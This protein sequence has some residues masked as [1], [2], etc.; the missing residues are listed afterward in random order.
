MT[1]PACRPQQA[2]SRRETDVTNPGP[3][4]EESKHE[5]PLTG[6]LTCIRSIPIRLPSRLR[7]SLHTSEAYL[8]ER[9]TKQGP[10]A[11]GGSLI[12]QNTEELK[13]TP[14]LSSLKTRLGNIRNHNERAFMSSLTLA[15]DRP[16]I[17]E[18]HSSSPQTHPL[19][20]TSCAL[21]PPSLSRGRWHLNIDRSTS[22]L[23]ESTDVDKS[24]PPILYAIR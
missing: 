23:H 9:K 21:A 13:V 5:A 7:P 14:G 2:R 20:W 18:L 17:L 12:P 16:R 3:E 4:T 22:P 15:G 8:G 24:V 19:W 6:V 1:T 10:T 11:L